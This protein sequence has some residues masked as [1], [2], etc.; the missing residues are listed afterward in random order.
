VVDSSRKVAPIADGSGYSAGDTEYQ[1]R[2]P[3]P[4]TYSPGH[5]PIPDPYSQQPSYGAPQGQ[6]Q[7]PASAGQPGYPPPQPYVPVPP[8]KKKGGAGKVLLIILAVLVVL[9]GGG[10]ALIA[11][12]AKNAPKAASRNAG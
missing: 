7:Y 11:V 6:P 1:V 5:N 3:G 10:I 2:H 12:V 4:V 8:R 9:C